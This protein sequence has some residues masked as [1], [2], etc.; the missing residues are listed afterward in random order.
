MEHPSLPF[1]NRGPSPLAKVTFFALISIALM[2]ADGHFHYLGTLRQGVA[3]VINPLQ[4]AANAPVRLFNRVSGFFV[5]QAKLQDENLDL[6]QK[7]VALSGELLQL[8]AIQQENI[9]LRKLLGAQ[10]RLPQKTIMAEILYAGR[11]PFSRKV[12]VNRGTLHGVNGG[13]A[14]I[15]DMGVIGQVTQVNPINSE[16]TLITDQDQVVPVQ[17]ARNGLRAIVFG[18]GRDGTLNLPYIPINADVQKGD[19][20]IT[21]GID[22]T[23]PQGLPVAV[24]T[25][26]ERNPAY[27]FARITC[28]PSAG[29]EQH[30]QVLIVSVPTPPAQQGAAPA[31]TPKPTATPTR[32]SKHAA[33]PHR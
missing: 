19:T 24:I 6:E 3:G 13:E 33:T 10:A 5:T 14:V 2:I 8:R 18:N 28:I 25:S 31:P 17:D 9:Q 16:V 26:V 21:S 23:Y 4:Y 1:F 11:D 20:L 30:R 32:S 22:G 12:T 29:V 15:D 27:P 7:Q